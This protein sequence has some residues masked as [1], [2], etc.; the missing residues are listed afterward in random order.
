MI[1]SGDLSK[2]GPGARAKTDA[3]QNFNNK[4]SGSPIISGASGFVPR[5]GYGMQNY[6]KDNFKL[7]TPLTKMEAGVP[8]FNDKVRM[9]P[10]VLPN[11]QSRINSQPL[12]IK[13]EH[14]DTDVMITKK[15]IQKWMMPEQQKETSN[16]KINEQ[17]FMD[18]FVDTVKKPNEV[19]DGVHIHRQQKNFKVYIK[20]IQTS[21]GR[22]E[23][24][25]LIVDGKTG[26][27]SLGS[28]LTKE[29]YSNLKKNGEINLSDLRRDPQTLVMNKKSSKNEAKIDFDF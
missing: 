12:R 16:Q 9:P 22:H 18:R 24:L 17:K 1:R 4:T 2:S 23:K 14:Q 5:Q 20:D 27:S 19:L 7:Q 8:N 15:D 3:Q 21:D 28:I 26:R 25:A 10:S 29:E 6:N 13:S 11:R